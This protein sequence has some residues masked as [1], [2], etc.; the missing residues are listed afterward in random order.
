M[1]N[2]FRKRHGG[3]GTCSLTY[4]ALKKVKDFVA[5]DMQWYVF[6]GSGKERR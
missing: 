2:N 3:G 1:I 4:I 6:E 5:L